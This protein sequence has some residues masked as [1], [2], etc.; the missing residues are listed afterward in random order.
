MSFGTTKIALAPPTNTLAYFTL[1]STI[2]HNNGSQFEVHSKLYIN[3]I[4]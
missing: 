3:L 1:P 2:E 4:F